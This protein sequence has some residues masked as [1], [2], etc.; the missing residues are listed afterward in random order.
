MDRSR[1]LLGLQRQ[2]CRDD[3]AALRPRTR[4]DSAA[5][6]GRAFPHSPQSRPAVAIR[7][8]RRRAAVGDR[9]P[10]VALGG[11]ELDLGGGRQSAMLEGVR[12]RLLDD[13]KDRELDPRRK[14]AI[15]WGYA[16]ADRQAGGPDLF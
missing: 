3:P 12:Q 2:V 7:S 9:E 1:K 5:V 15:A 11:Y 8:R 4:L 10:D 16:V 13:P 6:H 14:G